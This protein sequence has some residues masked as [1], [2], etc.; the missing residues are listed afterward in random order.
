M[1]G[2]DWRSFG[3]FHTKLYRMLG[4]RLVGSVG[5]GRKVLLLTTLGR[6][7]G[8][9]RTSP[10]VYMPHEGSFIVYASNGGK[11]S[12]PAWWLNL[13]SRPE[14]RVQI[15]RAFHDVTAR[16]L[17]EDEYALVWPHAEAYNGHWRD[18]RKNV[19]RHIP[20]IALDPTTLS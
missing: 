11:E 12:P 4:G 5:G 8:L 18:Y 19:K 13:Q 9:E 1:S 20:L 6:K 10:L 7:S 2:R 15:G 16:A 3:R 17:P 14:A